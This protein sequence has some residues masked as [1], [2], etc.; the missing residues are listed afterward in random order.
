MP[1]L[2]KEREEHIR[3][4]HTYLLDK[5]LTADVESLLAEID[6]LRA[7]LA[8]SQAA[9]EHDRTKVAECVTA[10]KNA[11]KNYDWLIEGR[12]SYEWNDDRWHEEFKRASESISKAIEPMVRI[13]A[14]WSN[15]PKSWPDVLAARATVDTLIQAGIDAESKYL[16]WRV[17]SEF[18]DIRN[19]AKCEFKPPEPTP[20]SIRLAALRAKKSGGAE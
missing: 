15:C 4:Y 9:P 11:L 18:C 7:D 19:C 5:Q 1:R 10:V 16:L 6:A 14:D 17:H 13:A 20:A 2:S 8:A 3:W 12:G